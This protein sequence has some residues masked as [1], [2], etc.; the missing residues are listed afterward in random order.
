MPLA[1]EMPPQLN[2]PPPAPR[3]EVKAPDAKGFHRRGYKKQP[4]KFD[5]SWHRTSD[6]FGAAMAGSGMHPEKNHRMRKEPTQ[7][8]QFMQNKESIKAQY[9]MFMDGHLKML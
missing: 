3:A 9:R 2:R 4:P 1:T 7:E 8:L 6:V 5:E